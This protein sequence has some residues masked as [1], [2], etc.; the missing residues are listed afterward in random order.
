MS[1]RYWSAYGYG[2]DT[3]DI[4]VNA[5]DILKYVQRHNNPLYNDIV[6]EMQLADI[7]F[8]EE[9]EIFDFFEENDNFGF[10]EQGGGYGIL[11]IVARIL[12]METNISFGYYRNGESNA[13]AL[14]FTAQFPWLL[15]KEEK[16]VSEKDIEEILRNAFS[17]IIGTGE[18]EK[19]DF[20]YIEIEFWG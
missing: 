19:L 18:A 4:H 12:R 9:D 1:T 14:M 7:P 16:N 5:N 13:E 20:G 3:A 11:S 6:E 17:E 2:I 15:S 10:C 8:D